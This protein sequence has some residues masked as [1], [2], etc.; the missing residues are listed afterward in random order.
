MEKMQGRPWIQSGNEYHQMTPSAELRNELPLGV[1]TAVQDNRTKE[2]YLER[3]DDK[4][5]FN[6]KLYDVDN[7]FINHVLRTYESTNNNLG[8]LLT[9]TKGTG[10]TVC[11]KIIANEIGLPVILCNEPAEELIPFIAQFNVPATFF[12]DEFEKKFEKCSHILLS[13]MDGAYNTDTRKVFILTTNSLSIDQNFIGRPS[14]IRYK[15]VFGN[16]TE[17]IITEYCENNLND[18]SRIP[19]IIGFIDTLKHSTIDIL[20]TIV[21]EINIH[22]CPIDRFRDFFNVDMESYRYTCVVKQTNDPEY[23]VEQF[24][25]DVE[26][27]LKSDECKASKWKKDIGLIKVPT[28][29]P[30][31]ELYSGDNFY[32]GIVLQ[33]L[34]SDNIMIVDEVWTDTSYFDDGCQT[35]MYVKVLNATSKPSLFKNGTRPNDIGSIR[36]KARNFN[37]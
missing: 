17:S 22:N 13:A 34:N 10:K 36:W 20:K 21:E 19:E 11:A 6:H 8:I 32:D 1:Y 18:K 9:G 7:A 30:I 33:P 3:I 37:C 14:R 24:K 5:T 23:T 35:K 27:Y 29:V 12:F 2:I 28:E 26:D 16:L 4:F 31:Q 25:L 15:K